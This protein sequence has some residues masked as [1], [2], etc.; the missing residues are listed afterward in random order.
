MPFR[1]NNID[2]PQ[3][4]EIRITYVQQILAEKAT[5]VAIPYDASKKILKE[6]F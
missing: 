2:G 6:L 4:Q 5:V 1:L 3:A